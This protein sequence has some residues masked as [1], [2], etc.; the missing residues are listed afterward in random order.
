MKIV[1][2]DLGQGKSAWAML[3][4]RTGE[5]A[6]GQVY[7]NAD[8]LRKLL[9]RIGPDQLVIERRKQLEKVAGIT[10]EQAR[11]ELVEAIRQLAER[12][13][14]IRRVTRDLEKEANQ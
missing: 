4:T 1:G 14:R 10:A 3:D 12:E 6:R 8:A 11:D 2:M 5:V 9:T 13:T 7:L